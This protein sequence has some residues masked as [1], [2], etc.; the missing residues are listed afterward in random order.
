MGTLKLGKLES[1]REFSVPL[2]YQVHTTALIGIRGSG[3][4]VAATVLAEEM[5]EHNLPFVAID[6]VGVWWGLRTSYKLV[7]DR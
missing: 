3:K 6:P 2:D 4:T 7:I 5:L 1:G